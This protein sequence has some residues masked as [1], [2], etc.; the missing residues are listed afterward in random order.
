MPIARSAQGPQRSALEDLRNPASFFLSAPLAMMFSGVILNYTGISFGDRGQLCLQHACMVLD[1]YACPINN[2][3]GKGKTTSST[4]STFLLLSHLR[5]NWLY[6]Q[7]HVG[8]LLYD[9]FLGYELQDE[10]RARSKQVHSLGGRAILYL[11][12]NFPKIAS[13]FRHILFS[14]R[15][16]SYQTFT[17]H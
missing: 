9:Q 7:H 14:E 8:G 2:L 13:S 15:G 1:L 16:W 10:T 12:I 3:E 11:R 6:P 17:L 4:I 5:H